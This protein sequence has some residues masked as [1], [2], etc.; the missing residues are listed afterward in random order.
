[1]FNH[2]NKLVRQFRVNYRA[3]IENVPAK[4]ADQEFAV[5]ITFGSASEVQR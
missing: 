4:K 5:L 3:V 2:D 1:M